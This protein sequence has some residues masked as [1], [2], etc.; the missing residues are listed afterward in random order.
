MIFATLKGEKVKV[1]GIGKTLNL[2][3]LLVVISRCLAERISEEREV[4]L[5]S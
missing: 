5:K 4:S 3:T 1:E 2:M